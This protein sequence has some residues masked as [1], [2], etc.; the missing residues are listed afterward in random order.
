MS[1]PKDSLQLLEAACHRLLRSPTDDGYRALLLEALAAYK[2]VA[3]D[4]FPSAV[5]D[6]VI[7]S[8][9]QADALCL[10]ILETSD[11]SRGSIDNEVQE[12]CQTLASLD[13]AMR[14]HQL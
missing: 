7:T 12:V 10:R 3:L 14:V 6:L 8:R 2:K 9:D 11:R 5:R 1:P 13:E 4:S